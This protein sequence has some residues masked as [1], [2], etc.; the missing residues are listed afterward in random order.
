MEIHYTPFIRVINSTGNF[1]DFKLNIGVTNIGRGNSNDIPID[2]PI[3]SSINSSL[4][5]DGYT[6]SFFDLT[7]VNKTYIKYQ[8]NENPILIEPNTPYQIIN[9]TRIQLSDDTQ[10]ILLFCEDCENHHQTSFTEK[11]A[12][13]IF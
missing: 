1:I 13:A 9:G 11:K 10:L 5:F 4:Y 6:F 3:I 7:E 12:A 8:E 2:D